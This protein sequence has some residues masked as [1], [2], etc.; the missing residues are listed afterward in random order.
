M[1]SESNASDVRM[2]RKVG[3]VASVKWCLLRLR[4]DISDLVIN[5]TH[6]HVQK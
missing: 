6:E 2:C 3:E 1:V 5:S 4:R